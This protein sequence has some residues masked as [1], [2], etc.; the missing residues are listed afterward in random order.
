MLQNVFM[1][2]SYFGAF[3]VL[4]VAAV[5]L[6]CLITKYNDW[7]EI[8]KG[9]LAA[10]MALGGKV[11]GVGNIVHYAILSNDSMIFTTVWAAVGVFLLLLI[12]QAFEWLTPKLDVNGEIEKGNK[13][14][15]FISMIFSITFSFVIGASIA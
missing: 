14:V 3:S 13:A 4:T 6:F 8:A 7:E 1:T 12:Y 10:G 2:L 9:N 15:G 11:F 5:T